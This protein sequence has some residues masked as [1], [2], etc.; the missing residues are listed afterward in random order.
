MK[1][2]TPMSTQSIRSVLWFALVLLSVPSADAAALRNQLAGHPSPYLAMHADGPVHWQTWGEEAI[3]LA[4]QEDKLLYVSSGYFSCHWCHVMQQESYRNEDIATR[5]NT[6]FVPVKI[7]RELEP[8]LDGQL[9]RFVEYTRGQGGWPLNVFMTPQGHPLVGVLYLPPEQ[10]MAFLEEL[11]AL[12]QKEREALKRTAREAAGVLA[13]KQQAEQ[14]RDNGV[15]PAELKQRFLSAAMRVADEMA[16]GFGQQT[17]FP[18]SPQLRSLLLLYQSDGSPRLRQFLELT[19]EQMA[20]RGL[21]DHLG[22]GFYRYTIDPSWQVPHFEK[23]LYDNA[24]LVEIYLSAADVLTRPA[25]ERIAYD[26]LDFMLRDMANEHG[27]FVA[28]LSAVDDRGEEGGYYL[29]HDEDLKRLLS[30]DEQVAAGYAWGFNGAPTTA[31]GH[32]PMRTMPIK[33]VA[34]NLDVA[35]AEVSRRLASAQEKLLE[36]RSKRTLPRDNKL[37]TA[38]N[39]LALSALASAAQRARARYGPAAKRVRDFL[40]ARPWDGKHLQRAIDE[41]GKGLGPGNLQ[42]YA[43][44]A[45]GL[46]TWAE[47]TRDEADYRIAATVAAEGWRRFYTVRGWRLA[48]ASLIPN[49][50][51]ELH[52]RDGALPSPS[53]TL[54]QVSRRLVDQ[55]ALAPYRE[56]IGSY[57]QSRSQ[58]LVTQPFF[59]AT[60]IALWMRS[61]TARVF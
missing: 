30:E 22:G 35:E 8:V 34:A 51:V 12:W 16:G 15:D 57:L 50:S 41:Q 23:M 24:Q 44:T 26:T 4:R 38:W 39:G 1:R 55:A 32:L 46:L 13:R 43:F 28:S 5:L 21:R 53:A 19:L 45:K 3:A 31:T 40:V 17:K 54:A 18:L 11:E 9:M 14:D 6:A 56:R 52:V 37:L 2:K 61:G 25:Y 48:E 60:H 58:A 49:P 59:H 7:D 20:N 42:D 29:W 36:A 10:F 47:L 27:V 33:A